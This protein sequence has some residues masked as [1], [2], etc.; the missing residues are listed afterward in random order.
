MKGIEASP[1][2]VGMILAYLCL[3]LAIFIPLPTAQQM[4]FIVNPGMATEA[5]NCH[6][7]TSPRK[8]FDYLKFKIL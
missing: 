1:T 6:V 8:Y 7:T 2:I 4:R 5:N 3:N